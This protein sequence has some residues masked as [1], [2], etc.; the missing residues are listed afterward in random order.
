MQCERIHEWLE[1]W[2]AGELPAEQAAAVADHLAGCADCRAER[3]HLQDWLTALNQADIGKGV[4]APR[5]LWMAIESRL[6]QQ[7][8]S[9]VARPSR[10]ARRPGRLLALAASVAFLAGAA[11][12]LGVLL[13]GGT[14]SAQ[15]TMVDYSILLDGLNQ[16]L[17]RAIQRFLDHYQAVPI[18]V[19]QA[20]A[21]APRLSFGLP[22]ELPG[23]YQREVVYRVQFGDSP[24]VAARYA[25]ADEPVIVFFHPVFDP[26][27]VVPKTQDCVI[28]DHHGAMVQ[29]GDWRLYHFMD[30]TTCHCILTRMDPVRE[31]P[32]VVPIVAPALAAH[33]PV[34]MRH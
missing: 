22:E 32:A 9:A 25:R 19:E 4:R 8:A 34:D 28:G 5:D 1:P 33:P 2:L 15:A 20:V 6:D 7:D 16:N 17:E 11:T 13:S 31:L 21:W 23:G 14:H 12:F 24:G 10:S 29:V 26:H 18:S 30:A 3:E 27:Q